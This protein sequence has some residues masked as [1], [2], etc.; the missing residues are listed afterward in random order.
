[1]KTTDKQ[2]RARLLE[3]PLN[4]RARVARNGHCLV[5]TTRPR[6]DGGPLPWWM[7]AGLREELAKDMQPD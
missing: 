2:I 1:M 4:L 7:F 6:G 5:Y 3:N